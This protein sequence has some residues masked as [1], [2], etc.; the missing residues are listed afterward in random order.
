MKMV[1]GGATRQIHRKPW[2]R[3]RT[4]QSLPALKFVARGKESPTP[5]GVSSCLTKQLHHLTGQFRTGPG[6][7]VLEINEG[8]LPARLSPNELGPAFHVGRSV[9][10]SPQPEVTVVGCRFG[11]GRHLLRVGQ[12]KRDVARAEEREDLLI[13]P[14]LVPE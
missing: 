10:F 9:I 1:I 4:G 11:G 6:V 12:A 3:S 13:E 2:P 7:L 8:L 14:R 5:S